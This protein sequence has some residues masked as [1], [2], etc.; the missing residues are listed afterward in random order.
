MLER[1]TGREERKKKR[2]RERHRERQTETERDS[3]RHR[4]RETERERRRRRERDRKRGSDGI[5][6]NERVWCPITQHRPHL[7]RINVVKG[8]R[9]GNIVHQYARV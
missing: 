1:K 7:P 4:E 2:D 3:E 6:G 8:L 9:V 5:G